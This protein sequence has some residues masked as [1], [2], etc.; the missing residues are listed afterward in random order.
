MSQMSAAIEANNAICS[1]PMFR[2]LIFE[3]CR[4]I[5]RRVEAQCDRDWLSSFSVWNYSC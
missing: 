4:G 2:E 3:W 5:A 1:Q